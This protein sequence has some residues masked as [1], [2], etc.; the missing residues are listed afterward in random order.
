MTTPLTVTYRGKKAVVRLAPAEPIGHALIRACEQWSI[1]PDNLKLKHLRRVLDPN[2]QTRFSGVPSHTRLEVI[3]VNKPTVQTST[4]PSISVA[5]APLGEEPRVF[6]SFPPNTTLYNIVET[7]NVPLVMDRGPITVS[8]GDRV[9]GMTDLGK[10]TLDSLGV[11]AG[12]ILLHV[13][14]GEA[15]KLEETGTSSSPA[16]LD[17]P[18]PTLIERT[19]KRTELTAKPKPQPKYV[20]QEVDDDPLNH[21]TL[22]SP[23]SYI[24]GPPSLPDE[25]FKLSAGDAMALQSS[26]R[27]EVEKLTTVVSKKVKPKIYYRSTLIKVVFPGNWSAQTIFPSSVGVSR[28]FDWIRG[29]LSPS[30][31]S[32]KFSLLGG[33]PPRPLESLDLSLHDA[34]LSPASLLRLVWEEEVETDLF[35]FDE[36][37]KEVIVSGEIKPKTHTIDTSQP[38]KQAST[39]KMPKWFKK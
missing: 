19:S 21:T 13:Y 23:Q 5:I 15:P 10:Y 33:V 4:T 7:L 35:V 38:V 11:T 28:I 31:S 1:E 16:V 32:T 6:G 2:V 26:S 27:A 3:E 12:S 14:W 34:G 22:Y 37:F 17:S 8:H 20:G 36:Q 39:R 29:I 18:Q 30:L 9:I 24:A 25:F